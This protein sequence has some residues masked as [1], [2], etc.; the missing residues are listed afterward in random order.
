M[1]YLNELPIAQGE[2]TFF[3]VS[4]DH[5]GTETFSSVRSENGYHI[6]AHSENAGH[7]HVLD[8]ARAEVSLVSE[9][10]GLRVLRVL[11]TAPETD[12]VNLNPHGHAKLPIAPGLYE[13][14][15]NRELGMDDMIRAAAD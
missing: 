14:R 5:F 7:H 6:V 2:V 1:A 10:D 12:V 15:I 4:D 9:Q 13:A 11:V 8:M 3:R